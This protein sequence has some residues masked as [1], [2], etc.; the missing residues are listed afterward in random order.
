MNTEEKIQT[1]KKYMQQKLCFG[2][3]VEGSEICRYCPIATECAPLRVARLTYELQ[4]LEVVV[5]KPE[6]D[7][8]YEARM[9]GMSKAK[10]EAMIDKALNRRAELET[11]IVKA[12][13]RE[14]ERKA[15]TS[16]S[17]AP[18]AQQTTQ[19]VEGP[20]KGRPSKTGEQPE[21]QATK[22][23]KT[24]EKGRSRQ[25]AKKTE[26]PITQVDKKRVNSRARKTGEKP[27]QQATKIVK[28]KLKGRP[29]TAKEKSE[30]VIAMAAKGMARQAIASVLGISLASIYRILK[31]SR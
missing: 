14:A 20:E 12:L 21:Q 5:A 29:R 27:E 18:G 7:A 28:L 13:G 4:Q 3:K 30:L 10:F 15:R 31:D 19:G 11:M 23:V 26:Q 9:E 1:V 17:T 6:A 8:E 22:V 2:L 16:D 25:V 24:K